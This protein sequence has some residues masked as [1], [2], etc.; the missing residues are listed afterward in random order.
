MFSKSP[1]K[2]EKSGGVQVIENKPKGTR[3]TARYF[4]T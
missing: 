3:I 2:F 1:G 4:N